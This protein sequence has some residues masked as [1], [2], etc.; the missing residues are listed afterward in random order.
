MK[1]GCNFLM[2]LI[3]RVCQ[4][5]QKN[6]VPWQLVQNR[7][8]EMVSQDNSRDKDLLD[9]Y[10]RYGFNFTEPDLNKKVIKNLTGRS[11][12]TKGLKQPIFLAIHCDNSSNPLMVGISKNARLYPEQELKRAI[13]AC[14]NS[15]KPTTLVKTMYGEPIISNPFV[16]RPPQIDWQTQ[17]RSLNQ[18]NVQSSS[19]NVVNDRRNWEKINTKGPSDIDES[20]PEPEPEYECDTAY[21]YEKDSDSDYSNSSESVSGVYTEDEE[22]EESADV[23][24]SI[25]T[26]M[27]PRESREVSVHAVMKH[28]P[29]NPSALKT[30]LSNP[31][32][33]QLQPS[34]APQYGPPLVTHKGASNL[35]QRALSRDDRKPMGKRI[36]ALAKKK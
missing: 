22:N 18:Q 31:P 32:S 5:Q 9:K 2:E 11:T 4:A 29:H 28:P 27:N 16:N 15:S 21:L 30:G 33:V 13:E 23:N 35:E 14:E 36:S 25:K 8:Q 3:E 26:Q 20:E 24:K 1:A 12:V 10:K 7:Y 17:H 19:S 6:N 34:P